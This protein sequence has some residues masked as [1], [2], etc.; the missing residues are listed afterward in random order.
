MTT[1]KCG[2]EVIWVYPDGKDGH[3]DVIWCPLHAAAG[4]MREACERAEVFFRWKDMLCEENR[5]A[6]LLDTLEKLRA[7]LAASKPKEQTT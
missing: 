3:D 7:A 6:S 1:L 5:A 4:Q 2:C